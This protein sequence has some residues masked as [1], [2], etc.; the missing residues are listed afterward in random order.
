MRGI[1]HPGYFFYFYFERAV[2]PA[3]PYVLDSTAVMILA[4]M[5]F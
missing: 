2:L 5:K 3:A 1:I 4:M